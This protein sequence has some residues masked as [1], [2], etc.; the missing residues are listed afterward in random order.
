MQVHYKS[1]L[2][3]L[4]KLDLNTL[5]EIYPGFST[6]PPASCSD[7][8]TCLY[9]GPVFKRLHIGAG[10]H[11][12]TVKQQKQMGKAAASHHTSSCCK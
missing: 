10:L 7:N 8:N 3:K 9:L 6:R 4:H 1:K 12:H 11:S 5:S 2:Y